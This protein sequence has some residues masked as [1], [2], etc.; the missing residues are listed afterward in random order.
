MTPFRKLTMERKISKLVALFP[1]MQL[2]KLTDLYFKLFPQ[3]GYHVLAND[4]SFVFEKSKFGFF[5]KN[6][7]EIRPFSRYIPVY[8]LIVRYLNFLKILK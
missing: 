7:V 6:M 4:Q 2:E 3:T 5:L 1:V 8:L